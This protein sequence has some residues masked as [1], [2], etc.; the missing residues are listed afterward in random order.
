MFD[1]D[2]FLL[3]TEKAEALKAGVVVEPERGAEDTA[4][5]EKHEEQVQ[6]GGGND[7]EGGLVT[8]QPAGVLPSDLWNRVGTKFIPKLK[9]AGELLVG[10]DLVVASPERIA[11]NLASDIRLIL[12]ELGLTDGSEIEER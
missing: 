9:G 2:V 3:Q 4:E 6:P 5:T 10:V 8:L 1:S 11:G 12:E 7:S